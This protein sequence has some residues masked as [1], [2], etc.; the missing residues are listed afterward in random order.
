V[1]GLVAPC[2]S[3]ADQEQQEQTDAI[4]RL[5]EVFEQSLFEIDGSH[6]ETT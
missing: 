2:K 4:R 5:P 1:V 3:Y 6:R